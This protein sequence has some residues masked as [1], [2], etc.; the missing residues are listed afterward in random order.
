MTKF[1]DILCSLLHAGR[2]FLL[3]FIY[4]V[5]NK[6]F[7]QSLEIISEYLNVIAEEDQP[8]FAAH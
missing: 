7:W 3:A 5:G 2:Q 6:G 8:F 1:T 4:F